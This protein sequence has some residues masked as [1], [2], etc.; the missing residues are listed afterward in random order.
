VTRNAFASL[1]LRAIQIVDRQD[2]ARAGVTLLDRLADA[3][4]RDGVRFLV[5]RREASWDRV[6][7]LNLTFWAPGGGEL[8]AARSMTGDQLAH[9]AWHH[10]V[11]RA[12]GSGT[13]SASLL[14]EAIASAFDLYLVG[15]LL[16]GAP[17]ARFLE[18]QVPRLA[19]R[20]AEAGLPARGF[21][22]LLER[23]AADPEAAFESLR[24][25]LY[26]AARALV[27][28]RSIPQAARTLERFAEHPMAPL[29]HHYELSNWLLYV[30]GNA[31]PGPAARA[32]ALDA[33]L[34]RSETPVATLCERLL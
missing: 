11:R 32:A 25:L 24:Q 18:E 3:L 2:Y 20:A 1:T 31:A 22:R 29:L 33:A 34:R 23:V 16:R 4:G 9:V 5:P 8:L 7:F 19:E 13:P 21:A 30:R 10:L 6:A 14:G 28:V 26:D 17:R 12:V 15:A 27:K